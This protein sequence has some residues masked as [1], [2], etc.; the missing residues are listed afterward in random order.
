MRLPIDFSL[1]I[2]IQVMLYRAL[3]QFVNSHSRSHSIHATTPKAEAN[4]FV[5][6]DIFHK[7]VLSGLL[8]FPSLVYN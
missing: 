5:K 4:N 7:E 1:I 6:N 2:L 8:E 3:R